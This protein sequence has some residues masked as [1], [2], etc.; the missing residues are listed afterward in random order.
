VW[1]SAEWKTLLRAV[2]RGPG[3]VR[4]GGGADGEAGGE[5]L[6]GM[7]VA[8]VVVLAVMADEDEDED[9]LEWK[10]WAMGLTSKPNDVFCLLFA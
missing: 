10:R 3:V 4:V 2:A 1:E 6:E 5:V 8:C 9:G 7:A